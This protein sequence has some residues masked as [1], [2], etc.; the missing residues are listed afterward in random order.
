MGWQISGSLAH[1]N[2]EISETRTLFPGT[3]AELQAV[4]GTQL[5]ITPE[6]KGNL[7][8]EYTFGNP[9]LGGEPFVRFDYTHVDESINALSGLEATAVSP[10]PTLQEAYDIANLRVGVDGG[11]WAAS[12]YINNLFDEA[13]QQFIN[14]RWA[15][16]RVSLTRPLT[17]G[18]NVRRKFQ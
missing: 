13:G 16:R 9:W 1:T 4:D 8:I 10:P 17:V 6:W 12:V 18:F 2:A 15:K 5:P 7:S 14:N 3:G 11:D